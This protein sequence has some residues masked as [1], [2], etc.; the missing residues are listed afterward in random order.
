MPLCEA[1]SSPSAARSMT[2]LK[3]HFHINYVG[4]AMP[5]RS[6]CGLWTSDG[7]T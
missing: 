5:C 6:K 3:F 1:Q 4:K 7:I 2:F